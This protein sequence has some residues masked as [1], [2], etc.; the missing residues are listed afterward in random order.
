MENTERLI[1]LNDIVIDVEITASTC[2][3][4]VKYWHPLYPARTSYSSQSSFC[5]IQTEIA[6]M[7]DWLAKTGDIRS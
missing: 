6:S 5:E 1:A 7:I 3:I 4:D 2:Y